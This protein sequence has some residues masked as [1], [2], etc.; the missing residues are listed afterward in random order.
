MII[1]SFVKSD[2]GFRPVKV[3]VVLMPGVS[4][5]QILGLADQSIKESSKRII[6]ALRHQGFRVPPGKQ[7]LV[8]LHPNYL[9]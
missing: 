2:F 8:N 7:V 9:K 1:N 6:A 3:E 4:Q 5:V